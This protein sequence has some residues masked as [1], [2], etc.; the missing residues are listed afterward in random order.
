[1]LALGLDPGGRDLRA[2]A[3]DAAGQLTA[4][5]SAD[6]LAQALPHS[7]LASSLAESRAS[8][9]GSSWSTTHSISS[10]AQK[11]DEIEEEHMDSPAWRVANIAGNFRWECLGVEFHESHDCSGS[12]LEGGLLGAH[13]V[14]VSGQHAD[15]CGNVSDLPPPDCNTMDD[16]W[17]GT[18]TYMCEKGCEEGQLWTGIK[19]NP[20]KVVNCV[21]MV[22]AQG[23]KP[24]GILVQR[25]M[26]LDGADPTKWKH[27]E[28]DGWIT[29][30]TIEGDKLMIGPMAYSRP[31]L[32]LSAA[33][34]WVAF[35]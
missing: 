18:D 28:P 31:N 1:M 6:L 27:Q 24:Q 4:A 11:D 20:S 15:V 2:V 33:L 14:W 13:H 26:L 35:W 3:V 19:L 10:M 12:K 17:D 34:I 5:S 25:G 30:W 9:L 22:L 8:S 16:P 23:R 32:A 7:V 29:E 21:K